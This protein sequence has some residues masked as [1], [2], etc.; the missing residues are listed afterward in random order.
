MDIK[1]I[2]VFSWALLHALFSFS[3]ADWNWPED[4]ALKT[5]AKEKQAYY[6]LLIAT[7]EFEKA[8]KELNWLY[9]NNPELH[10]TIYIEGVNCIK[11]IIKK[12]VDDNRK[13]ALQDS[14]LWMYDQRIAYFE[15]DASALDRKAYEAFQLYYKTPTKY[16]MLNELYEQAYEA[17]GTGISDFNLNSYMLLAKLYHQRDKQK[18]PA[19]K[20]LDIHT[21]ISDII[22][23]KLKNGGKADRLKKEQDKT[24]AW[25]SSIEGIL[26]C[27]FIE[28]KLLPKFKANPTDLSIAKKIFKYSV[29]AKC[30]DKPYFLEASE[31]V[32]ESDETTFTLAKVLGSKYLSQGNLSKASEYLNEAKKLAS[33][34]DEKFD[35]LIGL[36]SI[37]SK[38]GN[39]TKARSLA[40]EALSVKPGSAEAYNLIGNLYFK[41][42]DDCAGGKSKVVD[43]G[44]FLAAYAMY[45][46]AGN[47]SQM[48]AAKDQFPSKEEI[49]TESYQ[50]GQKIT[51]SCWINESVA[52]QTRD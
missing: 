39:K 10:Q 25:L 23:S 16:A 5:Q 38:R 8:F 37:N 35:A 9:S 12:G 3:Q 47:A 26:T 51:V 22:A 44:V 48:K 4:E 36:A 33:T 41:S 50:A 32:F 14:I 34:P 1:K 18:M 6:K 27:E 24:D 30:T 31:Q 2:I 15:N 21:Q 43:R 49:F 11:K 42:F 13:N 45:E 28:E 40:Y 46:K 29:Q 20:V 52:I 17:N 7:S 19:E